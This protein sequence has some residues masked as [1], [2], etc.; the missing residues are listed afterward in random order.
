MHI[1]LAISI[2]ISCFFAF[3]Q[4]PQNRMAVDQHFCITPR[5]KTDWSHYFVA[6]MVTTMRS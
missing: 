6:V 4:Y 5:L 2:T 1:S 3:Y